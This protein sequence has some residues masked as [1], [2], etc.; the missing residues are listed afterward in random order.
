MAGENIIFPKV[1]VI[2]GKYG[3]GSGHKILRAYAHKSRAESDL[4]LINE[5]DSSMQWYIDELDLIT[6]L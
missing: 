4:K 2:W 5:A 3:D 6:R 1:Y